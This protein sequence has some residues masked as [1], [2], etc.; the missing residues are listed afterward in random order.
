MDLKTIK[1]IDYDFDKKILEKINIEKYNKKNYIKWIFET[2]YNYIKIKIL[3]L[4]KKYPIYFIW[5]TC[6]ILFLLYRF[7]N[8][9][10]INELYKDTNEDQFHNN[11]DIFK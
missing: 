1:W 2:I 4:I 10:I 11:F 6:I 5:I 3:L 9:K 7:I 8:H